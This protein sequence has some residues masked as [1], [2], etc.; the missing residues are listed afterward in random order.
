MATEPHLAREILSYFLR[1]TEAA[2]DLQGIAGWRLLE[3]AIYHRVEDTALALKWLVAE[4]F[5][6]ED[7][8]PTSGTVFRLERSSHQRAEHFLDRKNTGETP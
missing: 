8:T 3:E 2:D 7:A 4:G 1:N 6:R 5:L